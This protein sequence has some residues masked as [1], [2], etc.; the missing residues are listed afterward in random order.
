MTASS[1]PSL[2]TAAECDP[3]LAVF[4]RRLETMRLLAENLRQC[5][6]ALVSLDLLRLERL[7][8]RM[9]ALCHELRTIDQEMLALELTPPV[10]PQIQER[11]DSLRRE[12]SNLQAEIGRLSRIHHSLLRRARRSIQV[13]TNVLAFCFP[14]YT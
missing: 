11:V 2:S 6:D 1:H 10:S 5:P 12:S 13:M 7:T 8:G 3:V 4:E 9:E 14:L